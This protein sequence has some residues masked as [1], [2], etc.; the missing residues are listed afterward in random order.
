M[1]Y[2]HDLLHESLVE[3]EKTAPLSVEPDISINDVVKIMK[4]NNTDFVIVCHDGWDVGI[5]TE[6]D[7]LRVGARSAEIMKEPVK[8]YMTQNPEMLDENSPLAATIFLM[9][10]SGYRHMLI[11]DESRKVKGVITAHDLIAKLA[12]VVEKIEA[13][14]SP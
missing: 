5:F 7:A 8:N 12:A 14:S 13:E 9:L 11:T 10:Q 6:R 3:A 4:K 1:N 2:A